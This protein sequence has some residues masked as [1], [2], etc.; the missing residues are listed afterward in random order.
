MRYQKCNLQR[1]R[2]DGYGKTSDKVI[3]SGTSEILEVKSSA[4][5]DWPY[6]NIKKEAKKPYQINNGCIFSC[7]TS[8]V[9]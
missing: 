3:V 1:E 7:T 2:E 5:T 6:H 4:Q 8:H 9:S